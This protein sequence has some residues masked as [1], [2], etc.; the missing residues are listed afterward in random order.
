ME[1]AKVADGPSGVGR[2]NIY[3]CVACGGHIV[4]VDRAEGTTPFMVNCQATDGCTGHMESSFYRVWDQRIRPSHEWYK[5][6]S[7]EG[8][9]PAVLHHVQMGGLMLRPIENQ[10]VPLD[11]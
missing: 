4:T 3:V 9:T 5:E 10:H 2:K 1:D 6:T 7:L 11:S 8:L